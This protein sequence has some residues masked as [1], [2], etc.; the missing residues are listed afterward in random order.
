MYYHNPSA[1]SAEN[2]DNVFLEFTDFGGGANTD[3]WGVVTPA[4]GSVTWLNGSVK[5]TST[6]GLDKTRL[7]WG[8]GQGVPVSEEN[9]NRIIEVRMRAEVV[10][11][12]GLVLSGIGWNDVEEACIFDL[13]RFYFDGLSNS[14]EQDNKWYIAR[15]DLY[16]A[17]GDNTL[18]I[19]YYGEDNGVYRNQVV[20]LG[21]KTK[22]WTR[23][24]GSDYVDKYN[25]VAWDVSTT[26]YF[27]WFFVRKW[28][29]TEPSVDVGSEETVQNTTGTA[30]IRLATGSPPSSPYLWGIRKVKVTTSLVV[31][32][33][34]NL[35]LRFLAQDNVT[36]ENEAVI[37]SR[38]APGAQVVTLTNLVVPHD[39][40]GAGGN[41]AVN[42][43]RVKLV[44]TDNLGNMILDNM[45]WYRV[46]QDD[47]GTRITWII[48]NWASHNSS[49]QDQLGSEISTIILNWASTPTTGDQHD[50]SQ[51][52]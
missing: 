21:P 43:K 31:N 39:L 41:P 32:Q 51:S 8:E 13:N 20:T 50:F 42:V 9:K 2:G 46:I 45:A 18:T 29:A 1:V 3:N 12:T 23:A 49:Q 17:N 33:G 48:L 11:R 14:S 5:T 47:W 15:A 19:F 34:D 7:E 37:W 36:I 24:N 52:Q 40:N 26:S 35:R 10:K 25:L 44:L 30:S 28:A 27:D 6:I 4:G 38:T 22:D 16:G